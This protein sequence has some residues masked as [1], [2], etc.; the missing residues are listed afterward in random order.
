M[1]APP[2][3]GSPTAGAGSWSS[4][5]GQSCRGWHVGGSSAGVPHP[6]SPEAG[7]LCSLAGLG[8]CT[9]SRWV[10]GAAPRR[11]GPSGPRGKGCRALRLAPVQLGCHWLSP[12]ARSGCRASRASSP[13]SRSLGRRPPLASW[14]LAQGWGNCCEVAGGGVCW[15]V[16]FPSLA[17][18]GCK[19]PREMR[20]RFQPSTE[21]WG[22]GGFALGG[23]KGVEK[24][25]QKGSNGS[26]VY[27]ITFCAQWP[28]LSA[29][30]SPTG[31]SAPF[32][33][34][35]PFR[36]PVGPHTGGTGQKLLPQTAQHGDMLVPFPKQAS[37]RTGFL[38][39]YKLH[40]AGT[41]QNFAP[42][43]S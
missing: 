42:L 2:D 36:T 24:D 19:V 38:L 23:R 35:P 40:E 26:R 21:L 27:Y 28:S 10:G 17:S 3:A 34:T 8:S 30:G 12:E 6:L 1:E 14:P 41:R 4:C 22:E 25:G 43:S 18:R 32:S 13:P 39:D 37:P 5:A 33:T 7:K 11:R 20:K 29:L 9:A 31:H 16:C 15:V